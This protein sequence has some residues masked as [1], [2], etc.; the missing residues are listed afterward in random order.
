MLLVSKDFLA[1]DF[2]RKHEF[3]PLLKA[4][5]EEGLVILWVPLGF[6]MYQGTEIA[7]YQAAPRPQSPAGFPERPEPR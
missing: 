1:S 4:E 3:P 5:E 2:I 7:N 6:S